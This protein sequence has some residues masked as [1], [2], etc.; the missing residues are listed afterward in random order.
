MRLLAVLS[1]VAP[2]ALL[3]GQPAPSYAAAPLCQGQ[4]PSIVGAP[5]NPVVGTAGD[6]VI[7]SEGATDVDALA[8]N[9]LICVTLDAYSVAVDAGPGDDTVDSTGAL[10]IVNAILG[11]GA[12]SLIGGSGRDNVYAAGAEAAVDTIATGGGSDFALIGRSGLPMSDVVDMGPGIDTLHLNGLPGTGTMNMGGGHDSVHLSDLSGA[13]WTIDNQRQEIVADGQ[14]TTL[15][16]ARDFFVGEARWARLTFVGGARREQLS[17]VD[18]NSRRHPSANQGSSVVAEMGGGDDVIFVRSDQ[19]DVLHGGKDDDTVNVGVLPGDGVVEGVVRADLRVGS[20]RFDDGRK[21]KVTSFSH[22]GLTGFDRFRVTLGD[23]ADVLTLVGCRAVVH[24]GGG[25]D[26][27]RLYPS[28]YLSSDAT[29]S[30]KVSTHSLRA[31]GEGGD[32]KLRGAAGDDVL[33]GGPGD[34][35]AYGSLG[36]DV[37]SAETRGGCER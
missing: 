34:D 11:E 31:Y 14:A 32:D 2:V 6:D 17:T 10:S 15:T 9:D 18:Y 22:V 1:V 35:K 4:A 30:G 37:C 13:E 7:V 21:A 16:G 19:V 24:A 5:G 26:R 28:R 20:V 12:D 36:V 29:C 23:G 33:I 3:G 8:G 25:G 27:V